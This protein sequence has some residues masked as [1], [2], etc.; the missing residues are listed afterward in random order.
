VSEHIKT[1]IESVREALAVSAVSLE[2]GPNDGDAVGE[3]LATLGQRCD[4]SLSQ[5]RKGLEEMVTQDEPE[6]SQEGV[7]TRFLHC[8]VHS[9]HRL[10][11]QTWLPF[12]SKPARLRDM[13]TPWCPMDKGCMCVT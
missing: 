12:V 10:M 8:Q 6:M 13:G 5:I 3:R 4:A 9:Q 2:S 7:C 11:L 1:L